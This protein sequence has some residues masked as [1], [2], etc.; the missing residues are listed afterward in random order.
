LID[1]ELARRDGV[2]VSHW[3]IRTLSVP[4]SVQLRIVHDPADDVVPFSDAV[5]IASAA[6]AELREA[7]PGTGHYGIIGSDAVRAALTACLQASVDH[8]R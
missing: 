4:S 7:Q 3:D 1:R 6:T 2:P 8:E 5:L